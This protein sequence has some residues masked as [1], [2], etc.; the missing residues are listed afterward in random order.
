MSVSPLKHTHT[1]KEKRTNNN[2]V[3]ETGGKLVHNERVE[4]D[5]RQNPFIKTK[6]IHNFKMKSIYKMIR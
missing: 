3:S 1:H 6:L 2:N 5:K 4:G